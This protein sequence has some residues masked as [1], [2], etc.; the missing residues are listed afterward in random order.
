MNQ[1][2][3]EALNVDMGIAPVSTDHS[4]IAISRMVPL[5]PGEGKVMFPVTVISA[6]LNN[7]Q[8]IDIGIVD[9]TIAAIAATGSLATADAADQTIV[10][11]R[12]GAGIAALGVDSM[13]VDVTAAAN[14]V[15]TINGTVF[16]FAAIPAT[17]LEWS[18]AATLVT[19]IN[20]SGLGL[21]ASAAGAVVTITSTVAGDQVIRFT[22]TVAA[23]AAA[24]ILILQFKAVMEVDASQ[25]DLENGATGVF[26]VVDFTAGAG[27][28]VVS[29]PAIRGAA[30]YT[31]QHAISAFA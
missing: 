21:T 2:L 30:R 10:Y 9:D 22:T 20:G 18:N 28:V 26:G 11:R 12:L 5:G 19:A 3:S 29:A 6:D 23:V 17:D 14:G 1:R 13:S 24:D 15:I 8:V 25:M 16:P 7:A 4:N 31:P 27:T